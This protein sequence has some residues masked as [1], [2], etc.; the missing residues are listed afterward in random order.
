MIEQAEQAHAAVGFT[1]DAGCEILQIEDLDGQRLLKAVL[2]VIRR[3]LFR[4][5][6]DFISLFEPDEAF[7]IAAVGVIRMAAAGQNTVDPLDGLGLRLRTDLHQ[8]VIVDECTR[9]IFH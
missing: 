7:H 6:E 5:I 3:A 1:V 8:L 9:G 4:V 2:L